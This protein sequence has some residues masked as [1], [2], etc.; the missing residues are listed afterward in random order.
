MIYLVCLCDE[1]SERTIILLI[2]QHILTL[3]KVIN[4]P[5]ITKFKSHK[6]QRYVY[7][8]GKPI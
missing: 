1:V 5:L 2:F 6:S 7:V 3:C 8:K 4:F